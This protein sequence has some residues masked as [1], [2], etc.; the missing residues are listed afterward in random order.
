MALGGPLWLV[1]VGAL[2]CPA[3]RLRGARVARPASQQSDAPR[4]RRQYHIKGLDAT[5]PVE[6]LRAELVAAL[7]DGVESV[8]LFADGRD[9]GFATL[10]GD[11]ERAS[12]P[13]LFASISPA[14]STARGPRIPRRTIRSDLLP[15]A[16]AAAAAA[17]DDDDAGAGSFARF[18]G[19]EALGD[20]E[21]IADG[22]KSPE[23]VG[24]M[25]RL[26]ATLGSR[27]L[28]HV[29]S[30]GSPP[31]LW[32]RAPMA[33]KVTTVAKGT[34]AV[35]S[36]RCAPRSTLIDFLARDDRVPVVAVETASD[37]VPLTDFQFP[38]RCAILL[39]GEGSGLRKAVTDALRPDAGDAFCIIPMAGPHASLNLATSLAIALYEYRRQWPAG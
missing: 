11:P 14:L 12:V 23:N 13:G 19:A 38:R 30:D 8:T 27:S 28:H 24:S 15:R 16:T 2:R 36:R 6:A 3:M 39:G 32:D 5:R 25:L 21:V 10:R 35:V 22:A 37:A 9:Y 4:P 1:M 26:M 18:V 33:A 7:G 20:V 34:D 29:H 17:D 31:P